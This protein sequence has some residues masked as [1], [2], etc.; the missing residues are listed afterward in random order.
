MLGHAI[1]PTQPGTTTCL[2]L[3][4]RLT[5]V[6]SAGPPG[7]LSLQNFMEPAFGSRPIV[8]DRNETGASGRSART[9]RR[10]W[11]SVLMQHM[12]YMNVYNTIF[13]FGLYIQIERIILILAL[14]S[15]HLSRSPGP[16]RLGSR[17]RE[18]N[19]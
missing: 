12:I 3:S 19:C 4:C 8:C 7:A 13:Y 5:P 11:P 16:R 9:L 15:R 14:I 6:F 17:R 1:K 18:G 2:R 10:N